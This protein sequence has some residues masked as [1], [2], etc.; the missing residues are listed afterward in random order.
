MPESL[1][2]IVAGC[3][4]Y[5]QQ[6]RYTWRLYSALQLIATNFQSVTNVTLYADLPGFLSPSVI[7][8][9]NLRPDLLLSF[10]NK[11]L[12]IFELTVGFET[13]LQTNISRKNEKY[14][15]LIRSLK[16]EYKDVRFINL[17]LSTLGV[18]SSL[19][20]DFLSMLQDLNVDNNHRNYILRNITNIAIRCTY[21]TFCCRNKEWNKPELLN[22]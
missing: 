8:G 22:F 2:H 14:R 6:G 11:C 20:S 12:Y 9:D 15:D 7:T 3:Q 4:F 17:P 10:Q 18:F 19:S 13:N 16:E 1:L 5:L 21:Y